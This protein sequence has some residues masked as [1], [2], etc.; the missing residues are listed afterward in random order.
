MSRQ[1]KSWWVWFL[2]CTVGLTGCHPMQPFYL[3]EDGD[4]SHYMQVA[5]DIEHPDVDLPVLPD[6]GQSL[7]PLSLANPEPNKLWD[8]SLEECISIALQN[9]KVIRTVIG[10]G[11]GIGTQIGQLQRSAPFRTTFNPQ[12]QSTVYDIAT[13]ESNGRGSVEFDL[14]GRS[15]RGVEQALA[16]FDAIMNITSQWDRTDQAQNSNVSAILPFQDQRDAWNSQVEITK[17]AATGTQLSARGITNYLDSNN[18]NRSPIFADW[19]QAFE[20]EARQPL[21]R[22]R[23]T[24]VNRVPIVIARINTDIA[25]TGFE[26]QVRDFLLEVERAY[27]ELF[28]YYHNLNATRV[29]RDSALSTWR[30][31]NQLYVQSVQGGEAENEAQSREQYF[32]F[33]ARLGDALTQ[34]YE[35]EG[36]L[37]YL[38]GIARSDG[39]LI[40]PVDQ[41]VT[42]SVEFDWHTA[43]AEAFDRSPELR[44]QKWRIK[45]AELRLIQAKNRLLPQVDAV[46]LY[47]FLGRGEDLITA[48]RRGLNFRERGSTA[49]DEL[50]EGNYQEGRIGVQAQIPIGFRRELAQV[51]GEQLSLIRQ[52]AVLETQELEISH[53]LSY[54]WQELRK[55]HVGMLDNL[56]RVRAAKREVDAIQAAY[57]A[58]TATLDRL[59]DAQR[60]RA[61][62][63]VS[64]F[65]S[66]VDYNL[67]IVEVHWRKGSLFDYNNVMLAEGPWP[68]KA[69]FDAHSRARKR[70]SGHFWKWGHSRPSVV[71]QGPVAQGVTTESTTDGAEPIPRGEGQLAPVPAEALPEPTTPP[72]PEQLDSDEGGSGIEPSLLER[73]SANA[74]P[75]GPSL[76]APV[77]TDE[78]KTIV[79]QTS[80]VEEVDSTSEVA[81]GDTSIGSKAAERVTP[82]G[83]VPSPASGKS[84]KISS[85]KWK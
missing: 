79:A 72:L 13:T 6:A 71:S 40:R 29:G 16:D 58:G 61:D 12:G 9:S 56:N 2:I 32:F 21:F 34:L 85:L 5:T 19:F 38:M 77:V 14:T 65:Q 49:F 52:R 76:S 28:F 39:R 60:R 45:A 83:T 44:R 3:H 27:W 63:E 20:F 54:A 53:A 36:T 7:E 42:A 47:R 24:Q 18:P 70:D 75:I 25:I 26:I 33:K 17:L 1:V 59:L 11:G 62:A 50:T 74:S 22:G 69:H 64:Y 51:R 81:S 4:L 82:K 78:D 41:P 35:A 67:S 68:G 43:L 84:E 73:G 66:L 37:R 8:L 23:G 57:E 10:G 31:I 80:F 30:R 15:N 46:L 55:D 48:N